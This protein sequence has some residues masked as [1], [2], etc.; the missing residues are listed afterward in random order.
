MWIEPK[1]TSG[2]QWTGWEEVKRKRYF[3]LQ[4]HYSA[5]KP[6][7]RLVF[8]FRSLVSRSLQQPYRII[9]SVRPYYAIALGANL[10]EILEHWKW[11]NRHLV[12]TGRL[13]AVEEKEALAFLNYIFSLLATG[14]E[15]KAKQLLLPEPQPMKLPTVVP[16]ES[17]PASTTTITITSDTTFSSEDSLQHS[18]TFDSCSSFTSSSASES[19]TSTATSSSSSS[20]VLSTRTPSSTMTMTSSSST[21]KVAPETGNAS[22]NDDDDLCKLCFES[23]IDT[24]ILDCGHAL[25]CA[26]CADELRIDAGC[27]VCRSP[28]RC[29]QKMYKC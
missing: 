18:T 24:V 29:V 4:R 11:V 14:K 9:V 17:E 16:E 28:I 23:P 13:D 7:E 26:R 10:K 22:D 8:G 5:D 19:S 15:D 27:P 21:D 1:E 25:L 12:K 20:H 6:I 3:V 2:G